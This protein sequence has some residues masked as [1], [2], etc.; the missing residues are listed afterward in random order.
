MRKY[1]QHSLE[2]RAAL[3]G[4]AGWK[5]LYTFS[6]LWFTVLFKLAGFERALSR[7][8]SVKMERYLVLMCIFSSATNLQGQGLR[9]RYS[10]IGLDGLARIENDFLLHI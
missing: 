10:F 6:S 4:Q 8:S 9:I 1:N 2:D 3:A 5:R 7:A